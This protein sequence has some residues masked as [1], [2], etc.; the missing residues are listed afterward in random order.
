MSLTCFV[1]AFISYSNVGLCQVTRLNHLFAHL[2]LTG[3]SPLEY[4]HEPIKKRLT[5][6]HIDETTQTVI[7]FTL[8]FY[9]RCD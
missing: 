2:A 9:L 4:Q 7:T 6:I 8:S 5:Q 3:A 1:N